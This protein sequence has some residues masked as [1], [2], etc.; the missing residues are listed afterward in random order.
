M[1]VVTADVARLDEGGFDVVLVDFVE[2]AFDESLDGEL[3]RAVG[4]EARHAQ[5]AAGGGEDEVAALLALA[6][7]GEGE[8]DDVQ[9]AHEVG[10]ELVADLELVLV[11]AGAD[12]AVAGADGDDV[13][14]F[15]AGHAFVDD[16]L[17]GLADAHVAE[18][19][20]IAVVERRVPVLHGGELRL[21]DTAYGAD[22]VIVMKG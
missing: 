22:K 12:D 3:G 18:E 5:R 9:G 2:H 7:V 15:E 11:L 6:E 8:L 14:A 10:L 4:P 16:G 19:A 20:E 1:R 21:V 17:D 13:D